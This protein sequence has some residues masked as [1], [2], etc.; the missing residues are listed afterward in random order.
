MIHFGMTNYDEA[1]DRLQNEV[2][3]Y[4]HMQDQILCLFPPLTVAHAGVTRQ[5]SEPNVLDA[6]MRLHKATASGE[7]EMFLQTDAEQL[8][9]FLLAMIGPIQDQ[10]RLHVFEIITQTS[11][12]VGHTVKRKDGDA[13]EA[14]VEALQRVKMTFDDEGRPQY[15]VFLNSETSERLSK[16]PPTGE[17]LKRARQIVEAKRNSYFAERR[18]R[19]LI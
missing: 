9:I 17:Q 8:K 6:A 10:Q 7:L 18:H 1:M 13:W 4:L 14:Y 2:A 15:Q 5:V 11:D 3:Y 16:V 12:A 19:R